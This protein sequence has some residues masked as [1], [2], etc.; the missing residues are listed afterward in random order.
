MATVILSGIESPRS[1]STRERISCRTVTDGIN[2]ILCNSNDLCLLLREECILVRKIG[3]EEECKDAEGYSDETFNN[4]AFIS[5][6]PLL[7]GGIAYENP[8]PWPKF[9][10]PS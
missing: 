2:Q 8:P 4:L 9:G 3:D 7:T 10:L 6:I 1:D 5:V